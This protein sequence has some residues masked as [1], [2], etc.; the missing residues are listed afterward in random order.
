MFFRGFRKIKVAWNGLTV[1]LLENIVQNMLY[2]PTDIIFHYIL[3]SFKIIRILTWAEWW[4][5][6]FLH[7]L[8]L[9]G[10]NKQPLKVFFKKGVP[11]NVAKFTWKHF[12]NR[13]NKQIETFFCEFCDNF[14]NTFLIELLWATA[15]DRWKVMKFLASHGILTNE[16]FKNILNSKF[17]EYI[18]Y[19]KRSI[20]S[21]YT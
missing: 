21:Q 5:F 1:S 18:F 20:F 6:T 8:H 11:K 9:I 7:N 16:T 2:L 12:F 10:Q 14:K 19:K 15:S 13:V 17:L 3:F 4:C